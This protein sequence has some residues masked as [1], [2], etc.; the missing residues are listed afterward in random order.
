MSEAMH[1]LI[2]GVPVVSTIQAADFA[3]TDEVTRAPRF[4]LPSARAA[5]V[6]IS[7][8]L[9]FGVVVGSVVSP[10]AIGN[11]QEAV[12]V[13]V[14]PAPITPTTTAQAPAAEVK[15]DTRDSTLAAA[16]VEAEPPLTR[17]IYVPA[18]AETSPAHPKPVPVPPPSPLPPISHVFLVVLSGHGFN[19]AFGPD[20]QATYL[21]RT[22]TTHG[23]LIPSHY[24]ITHGGLGNEIAM[25]SGQGPTRQ[26]ADNCPRYTD[27]SPGTL[28]DQGQAIGD[29]CVYPADIKTLAD[30]LVL[31]G[32]AWKAYI[33]GLPASAQ[34]CDRPPTG[35]D[36][37]NHEPAPDRSTVTW[38]NPF[39]YFRSLIESPLCDAS[40]A[41]LSQLTTD[42]QQVGDTPALSYIVPDRCHDGSDTVCDAQQPDRPSGLAA[43]D[44]WLQTVIPQIESSPAYRQGGLIAITFDSAPA[45]GPEADSGSCCGQPNPYPNL[46][47]EPAPPPEP[48][49]PQDPA[50]AAFGVEPTGGGGKVG[51]LLISPYIKPNAI[52]T[53]GYFNHFSLFASLQDLFTV[54]RTAYANLAE[55][56]TFDTTVFT[57]YNNDEQ[58]YTGEQPANGE[59]A[60]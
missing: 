39:L 24:A 12:V 36:D 23:Q 25:I 58:G 14:S 33:D 18:P 19:A 21:S 2:A 41:N 17:T 48:S 45:D 27:L 1:A 22:L 15:E 13:A 51:L 56:P 5:A 37:P 10:A 53:T 34:G 57:A 42:L 35:G 49:V 54:G 38:R 11:A 8:I 28:G 47:A 59:A 46:P 26:T 55:L 44:Q 20:S 16:P 52:N 6:A 4:V 60:P 32:N 3:A 29:G 7:A 9:G 30:Q 40:I 50:A 31:S 43:A